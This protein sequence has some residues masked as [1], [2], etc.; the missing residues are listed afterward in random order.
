MTNRIRQTEVVLSKFF[1]LLSLSLS[2]SV[3]LSLGEAR[4]QVATL[5]K[6]PTWSGSGASING[7]RS[8]LGSSL[9]FRGPQSWPT[10]LSTV[11]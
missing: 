4:S 11:F 2:V 5:M 6:R 10:R 1:V 7:H 9:A 8:D 3:C